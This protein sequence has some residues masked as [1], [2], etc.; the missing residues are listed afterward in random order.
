MRWGKVGRFGEPNGE[1]K[2][3]EWYQDKGEI[4]GCFTR[5][6]RIGSRL[7]EAQCFLASMN[8]RS[9]QKGAWRFR[10]SSGHRWT[11]ALSLVKVWEPACRSI[12]CNAGSRSRMNWWRGRRV[13]TCATSSDGS[14]QVP[15][16][17][18][19]TRRDAL[20][21]PPGYGPMQVWVPR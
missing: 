7:E 2:I 6:H 3:G 1:G 4:P 17:W 8:I 18:N 13:M 12:R 5:G 10:Q 20:L 9:T 19:W 15:V 14:I 11:A 21:F 16:K